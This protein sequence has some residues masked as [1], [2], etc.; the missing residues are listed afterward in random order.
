M[1]RGPSWQVTYLPAFWVVAPGSLG[2]LNTAH[3]EAGNAGGSVL[4][5]LSAVFGVAVGT[6]IGSAI[7]RIPVRAWMSRPAR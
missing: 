2:L 6:L 5:A 3:I 1:P 4:A 7:S